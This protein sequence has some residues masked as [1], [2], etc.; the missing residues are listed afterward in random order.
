MNKRKIQNTL[1]I[2]L[3]LLAVI[4]HALP[5]AVVYRVYLGNGYV[6]QRASGFDRTIMESGQFLPYL[7]GICGCI[8]VIFGVFRLKET[9]QKFTRRLRIFALIG[10]IARNTGVHDLTLE[11][12]LITSFLITVFIIADSFVKK[13]ALQ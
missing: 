13:E 12:L 10:A 11:G 1:L 4:L 6:L 5:T 7:A 8:C 9:E 3:P 2:L